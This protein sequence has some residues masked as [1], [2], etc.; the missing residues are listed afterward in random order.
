MLASPDGTL[1]G[2][3]ASFD[4]DMVVADYRRGAGFAEVPADAQKRADATVERALVAG[5]CHVELAPALLDEVEEALCLGLRDY[6]GKLG[7]EQVVLGLSGGVDS[8][9]TAALAARVVGGPRVLA[10]EMPYHHTSALSRQAAAAVVRSLG[11]AHEVVPIE[12]P[13]KAFERVLAPLFSG[14]EPDVTEENLQARVRGTVLMALANKLGPLVLA[15]GNKSELAT[16][17]CTLYGD[18]VGGLAVIGDLLK[19]QVYG[20]CRRINE[21]AGHEVIPRVVLERPPSAELRA[22][23]L[24][25]DALPPYERL[26]PVL[27]GILES[28]LEDDEISERTGTDLVSVTSI[29][30]MVERAEFKRR[31]APPTLRTSRSSWPA[32]RSPIVHRFGMGPKHDFD[33][34][35]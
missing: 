6:L 16:G 30:R 34:S 11:L 22:G 8:A 2:V 23:Q 15:T 10:V 24:D 17:Y 3:A 27:V 20:L 12:E 18:M 5:P 26:D 31:Q 19:V 33:P 32:R 28:R 7:R 4:E 14:L 29:R 1:A 9:L 35:S 21:R 25:E 13:Q